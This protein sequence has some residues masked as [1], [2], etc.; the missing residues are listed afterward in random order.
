MENNE[1]TWIIVPKTPKKSIIGLGIGLYKRAK[2]TYGYYKNVRLIIKFVMWLWFYKHFGIWGVWR[3][4]ASS[5]QRKQIQC[6]IDFSK[7]FIPNVY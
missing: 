1:D 2:V 7:H 5:I 3:V 6:L 4:F